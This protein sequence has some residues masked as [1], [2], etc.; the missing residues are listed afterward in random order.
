ML[1]RSDAFDFWGDDPS[2]SS[3]NDPSSDWVYWG[4]PDDMSP[5]QAGYDT[6]IAPG[7]GNEPAGGW[8]EVMARTRIMNWNR[9]RGG[10]VILDGAGPLEP[11]AAEQVLPE[12]GTIIRWITNKPNLP[13]DEFTFSTASLVGKTIEYNP[14]NIKVWPNPYFAYNPEETSSADRQIHFTHLP[15]G[16]KCIIRIFDLTGTLVRKIEHN[17]GT[18]YE[19]WDVCDYHTN[20][21]ASGMYIVHIETDQGDKILKLAIVQPK[22]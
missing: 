13:V 11:E 18:Q 6:W 1:F 4:N 10:G 15:A 19:V 3:D 21:V 5:G 7:V 16:G 12:V 20:P 22:S 14:S 9:Y 17:N 8:T 2:S